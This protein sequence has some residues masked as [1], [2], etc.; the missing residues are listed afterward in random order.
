MNNVMNIYAPN[1]ANDRPATLLGRLARDPSGNT[2]AIMAAMLL[3][4]TALA[5]S[6]VDI[7]RLYLVKVRLQQ[8]CDSAVLAGRRYL[9]DS[10]STSLDDNTITQ[11]TNFFNNNFKPGWLQTTDVTFT[12]VKQN[13]NRVGGTASATVPMALMRIFGFSSQ[14]LTVQCEAR[15][16]IA[17]TD[18]VFVLDTTGSM[19]CLPSD[20]DTTC[21]S[22]AGSAAKV[23]YARPSDTGQENPDSRN[24]SVPGYPGSTGYYVT[25]KSG[26]RI[27]ALRTAVVDFYKTLAANVQPGTHVRYGFVTYTS[28]V[29]AGRAVLDASAESPGSAY[30]IGQTGAGNTAPYQSR[31]VTADFTS[32]TSASTVTNITQTNC[33]NRAVPRN[34]ATPLTYDPSTGQATQTTVTYSSSSNGTCTISAKTYIPQ[35]TYTSVN[36]DVS[37]YITS[38]SIDDPTKVKSETAGWTGCVEEPSTTPNTFSFSSAALPPDINPDIVPTQDNQRWVPSFI[39]AVYGRNSSSSSNVVSFTRTSATTSNGD[40]TNANINLGFPYMKFNS[41][42]LLQLG[43]FTCGKP[44]QR[45]AEV[46]EQNVSDYV[47]APDFRAIGGTYHDEGMIWGVRLLSPNG[48]FKADTQPW[49]GRINPPNRVIVFLTDGTIAPNTSIYG[50]HG[51]EFFDRRVSGTNTTTSLSDFHNARFLAM[52]DYAKSSLNINVWTVAFSLESTPQLTSCASNNNQA[53]SSLSGSD[54]S[55]KFKQIALHVARLRLSQ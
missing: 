48:I 33:N 26:S 17:D 4:M 52:C 23:A 42:Q 53:L 27:S 19:A 32:A 11:A 9:T 6:T 5:G 35:W 51:I 47:N 10:S 41:G 20:D 38:K 28:V 37:S 43:F 54:L 16:D 46:T 14:T 39:E 50:A 36:Q 31:K 13:T 8:A 7:A 18:I 34:P 40:T 30:M 44:V 25:E 49:P 2:L 24:K 55:D 12:P 15:F 21:A 22:Y 1:R 45:L 3:P 29:N